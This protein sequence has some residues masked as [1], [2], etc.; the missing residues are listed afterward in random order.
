MPTKTY[1]LVR[2]DT[3]VGDLSEAPDLSDARTAIARWKAGAGGRSAGNLHEAKGGL[4]ATL[5]W[6][7]GDDTAESDLHALCIECGVRQDTGSEAFH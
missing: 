2:A 6:E 7:E 1:T 5:S 3:V 4:V